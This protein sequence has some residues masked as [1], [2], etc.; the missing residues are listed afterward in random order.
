VGHSDELSLE[1]S[2]F[3]GHENKD[4]RW[5]FHQCT[6]LNVEWAQLRSMYRYLK[7]K[8]ARQNR[9]NIHEG[10]NKANRGESSVFLNVLILSFW[11]L[12]IQILCERLV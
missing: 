8:F 2:P 11:N 1:F 12:I 5:E 6:G 4:R 7:K 9:K 10:E 3:R